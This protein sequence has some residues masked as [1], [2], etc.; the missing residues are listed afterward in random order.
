MARRFSLAVADFAG[1]ARSLFSA[2]S[3]AQAPSYDVPD[4]VGAMRF[5]QPFAI[6]DPAENVLSRISDGRG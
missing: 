2:L 3:S 5:Y 4:A 6:V 1:A